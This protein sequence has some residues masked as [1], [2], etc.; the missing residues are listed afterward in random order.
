MPEVVFAP[1]PTGEYCEKC[2]SEFVIKYGRYGKFI[3]CS[4]YPKCRNAK[5]LMTKVGTKC[6]EC[7]G[8]MVE[9]KTRRKRLFYSCDQYPKC[10]FAVWNRPLPQ[11]EQP[12]QSCGGLLMEAAAGQSKCAKCGEVAQRV[13][14]T[15]A[16][17]VPAAG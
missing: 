5:S 9:K 4:G 10:T 6:P 11:A 3:A 1:E 12:C 15:A 8:E 2:G 7:G 13:E 16:A 14:P 17:P